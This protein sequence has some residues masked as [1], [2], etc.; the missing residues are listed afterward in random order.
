MRDTE[1]QKDNLKNEVNDLRVQKYDLQMQLCAKQSELDVVK[2]D[3]KYSR[4]MTE[5]L[6][7]FV[8]GVN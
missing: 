2:R 5:I 8:R 6:N 4:F 7:D 1:L 3:L